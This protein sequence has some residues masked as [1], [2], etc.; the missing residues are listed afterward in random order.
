MWA[1]TSGIEKLTHE[2]TC[3]ATYDN[4]VQFAGALLIREIFSGV[5][6]LVFQHNP[7]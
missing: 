5:R 6:K 4:Q 3:P 2:S 7:S 1:G